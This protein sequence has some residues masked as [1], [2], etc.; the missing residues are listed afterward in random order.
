MGKMYVGFDRLFVSVFTVS[1]TV[2]EN[3]SFSEGRFFFGRISFLCSC[4][5]GISKGE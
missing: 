2:Q 4:S 5:L 3:S 1:I